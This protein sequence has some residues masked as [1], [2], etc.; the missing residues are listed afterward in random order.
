MELKGKGR[1]TENGV[2]SGRVTWGVIE[3]DGRTVGGGTGIGADP[4]TGRLVGS[5]P[6]QTVTQGNG[7][8]ISRKKDSYWVFPVHL[9]M[10][11]GRG[12]LRTK[13][14]RRVCQRRLSGV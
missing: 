2:G 9:D 10:G 14:V 4:F 11:S 13:K 12:R 6:P 1:E 8:Q 7:V 3:S 5:L